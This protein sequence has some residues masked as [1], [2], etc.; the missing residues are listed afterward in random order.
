MNITTGKVPHSREVN[1]LHGVI[2]REANSKPLF[3]EL[4]EGAVTRR[5]DNYP[6]QKKSRLFRCHDMLNNCPDD[7][8]LGA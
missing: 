3:P 4:E 8:R 2:T 6:E 1:K 5:G 7:E